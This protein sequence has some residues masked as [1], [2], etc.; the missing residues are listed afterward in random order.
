MEPAHLAQAC[1]RYGGTAIGLCGLALIVVV[2]AT[3][4]RYREHSTTLW[5]LYGTSFRAIHRQR[6]VRAPRVVIGQVAREDAPEV[7][8]T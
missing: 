4:F 3:N 8:L 7:G 1:H 2:E 6:Q 5:R